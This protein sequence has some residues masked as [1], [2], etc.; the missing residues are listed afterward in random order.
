MVLSPRPSRTQVLKHINTFRE[1]KRGGGSAIIYKTGLSVK[2]GEASSS[3]FLSFEYSYVT[4]TLSVDRKLLLC[5]L[6]RKQEFAFKELT[7]FKIS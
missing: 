3:E 5:C 6:Y 4:L 1:N 2:K 7:T